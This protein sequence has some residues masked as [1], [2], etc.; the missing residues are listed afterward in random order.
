[1]ERSLELSTKQQTFL[2]GLGQALRPQLF[3]GHAGSTTGTLSALEDLFRNRELIKG[4][5]LNTASEP[6]RTIAQ[7]LAEQAGAALVGVVGHTFVLYRPNP[8]LKERLELPSSR[9]ARRVG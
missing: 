9:P 8:D 6:T 4:R 2:R 7:A 1:M 3:I 5:V